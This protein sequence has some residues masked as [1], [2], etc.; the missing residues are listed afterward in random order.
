M[1]L[2]AAAESLTSTPHPSLDVAEASSRMVVRSTHIHAQKFA[3]LQ[4]LRFVCALLDAI[5]LCH[6]SLLSLARYNDICSDVIA[7]SRQAH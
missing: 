1:A 7:K 4:T 2:Y 3:L 6:D 5:N